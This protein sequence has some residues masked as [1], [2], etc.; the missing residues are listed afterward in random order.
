M[1]RGD[2]L[3]KDCSTC[4]NNAMKD[5]QVHCPYN[6]AAI[7]WYDKCLLKYSDH[8]FFGEMDNQ[9]TYIMLNRQNVKKDPAI[10][11]KKVAMLL[12]QLASKVSQTATLYES[13]NINLDKSKKIYWLAQYA[14]YLSNKIVRSVLSIPFRRFKGLVMRKKEQ[15]YLLVGVATLDMRL[16]MFFKPSRF[17][18]PV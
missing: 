5:I 16:N 13:G 18:F 14:L 12:A 3:K 4:V 15:G 10:F 6:K 2:V 11:D 8:L 9:N 1:C 7:I 17:L